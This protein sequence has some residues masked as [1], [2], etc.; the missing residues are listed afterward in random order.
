MKHTLAAALLLAAAGLPATASAQD[1]AVKITPQLD[2]VDVVHDGRPLR[3][4]RNQD[5]DNTIHPAFAKTSR[6]CPPFCVQPAR[7][8]DGVATIGEI[9]MLDYLQRAAAGDRSIL[10]IDSRGPD[11]LERGTIP[12]SV[13]LHYKQ[14][15]RKAASESDIAKILIDRFDVERSDELWD[16]RFAK[17]LVLFCNGPWCGQSPT[18][19]KALL[20]LGYPPSKLK[21]YRGGMQS[22]EAVGLTTVVPN[23]EAR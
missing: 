5:Q 22:W 17:T 16:F 6:R 11:W 9:E 19:I 7:M 18:N 4:Q 21:W 10:V 23:E 3:I 15:S 8:P 20:R 13:N 1:I 14:L 12:G 2:G